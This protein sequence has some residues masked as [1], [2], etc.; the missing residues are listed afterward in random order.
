MYVTSILFATFLA[1]QASAAAKKQSTPAEATPAPSNLPIARATFPAFG[2]NQDIS[3][4][5]EFHGLVSPNVEIISTGDNGLHNFPEGGPFGYHSTIYPRT[6][7]VNDIVHVNPIPAEN[8]SC[9]DAGPHLDPN[10][11]GEMPPCNP[12]DPAKCQ[13]P[14]IFL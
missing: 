2:T 1:G 12:A 4:T 13:V 10:N 3:G 6:N 7:L 11:V 9:V 5:L 8:G 14:L